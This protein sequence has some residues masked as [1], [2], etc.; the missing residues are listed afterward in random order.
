MLVYYNIIPHSASCKFVCVHISKCLVVRRKTPP[1]Q[2]AV[3][4]S[5]MDA[6]HVCTIDNALVR[7]RKTLPAQVAEGQDYLGH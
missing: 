4:S 5:R 2:V 6:S 7:T 1:V 3:D